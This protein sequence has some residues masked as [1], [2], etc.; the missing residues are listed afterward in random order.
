MVS[1]LRNPDVNATP[2]IS[3]PWHLTITISLRMADPQGSVNL[4]KDKSQIPWTNGVW[5]IEQNYPLNR[6]LDRDKGM[7]NQTIWVP[8]HFQINLRSHSKPP[9]SLGSPA[10]CCERIQDVQILDILGLGRNWDILGIQWYK[11]GMYI[12]I[13]VRISMH[14]ARIT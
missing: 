4:G 13:Y 5:N 14:S 7:I 3:R 2:V 9:L 12:Y 6:H 1:P 10:S 8:G 11:L